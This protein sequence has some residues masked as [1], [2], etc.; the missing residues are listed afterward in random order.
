V[1]DLMTR[2]GLA[3]VATTRDLAGLERVSEARRPL[4]GH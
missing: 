3:L 2:A 4:G 1:R